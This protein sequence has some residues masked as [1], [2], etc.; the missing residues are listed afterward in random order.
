MEHDDKAIAKIVA[1]T[2]MEPLQA[3]HHLQARKLVR[4]LEGARRGGYRAKG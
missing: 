3:Y 4:Q 2:G 1:E